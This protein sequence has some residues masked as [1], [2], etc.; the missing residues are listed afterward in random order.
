[1][2]PVN[3]R[4]DAAGDRLPLYLTIGVFVL[5][6][7]CLPLARMIDSSHDEDRPL[8]Q[9]MLAMQTMQAQLVANKERP[10]E[11]SVSDGETVEVGK[12]KTFTVSSGVTIEVRV[13]DHDS[14]CVSGH[15]DLGATSPERCSS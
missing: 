12:N 14:F 3:D 10:V 1:M 9:D 6:L 11:V 2:A 15:N 5:L 7:A 4:P 13:V 8:Y